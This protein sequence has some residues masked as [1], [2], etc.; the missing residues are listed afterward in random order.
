[1]VSTG[2]CILHQKEGTCACETFVSETAV[3]MGPI[4]KQEMDWYVAT[5][6]PMDKAGAYGIQGLGGR[7]VSH[8]EGDYYT[9]V[10]LPVHLVYRYF[11]KEGILPANFR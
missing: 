11:V 1:M 7:F 4:S 10:G 6:E 3:H 2:V 9:I 8:V 5:G